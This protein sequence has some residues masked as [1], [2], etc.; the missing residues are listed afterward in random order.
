M[1]AGEAYADL[2]YRG[3]YF[4]PVREALDSL[5]TRLMAPVTGEVRVR[6]FKGQVACT[7]RRSPRS[8]YNL[9][10]S[11]FGEGSGYD[12]A[13]AAGFI[14]L[15]GLPLE[16]ELRRGMSGTEKVAAAATLES[17]GTTGAVPRPKRAREA[18]AVS[19][20]GGEIGV[21]G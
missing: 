16:A 4:T 3:M 21:R 12:Q 13:D 19:E 1:R 6:L 2:V 15:F 5:V 11:T 20:A 14:R 8:L 18:A 10:L 7:G 17:P 9:G